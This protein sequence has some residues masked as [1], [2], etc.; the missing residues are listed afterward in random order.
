MRSSRAHWQAKDRKARSPNGAAGMADDEGEE[1]HYW[2]PSPDEETF[3]SSHGV[4]GSKSFY[5]SPRGATLF[6]RAWLPAGAAPP[7]AAVCMVH[8][9]GNDI[10]WTF[11]S[12]AVFLAG[13][14][15]ACFALD[16]PGHGRSAGLRAFVPSVDAVAADCAAFFAHALAPFPPALPRFL[17]GESMGAA[18]CLLLHLRREGQEEEEKQQAGWAGAVLVAPMLRLSDRLR[19]PWPLPQIL[20][21]VARVAPELAVVPTAD[22]VE[23]SVRV[24]EKRAVARR[25]PRRYAGRPRLGTVVE[26]MRVTEY[27]YAR[28]EEVRLPFLVVHGTGDAVTD[29]G[30]SRA[31]YERAASADKTA[32]IL[33]GLLHSL[34]FGETDDNVALVR[35]LILDWLN[36]RTPLP[37]D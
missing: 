6:T 1:Q 36:R 24:A 9:Y 37:T 31:L 7:R 15:Y 10:S 25:N 21:V 20:K 3:Y 8:G 28:L 32:E 11:Q 33:D 35:R 19:P 26:L 14:G 34:L 13:A 5:K 12:T 18:I 2:G 4:R 22:L 29:A 17:Y 23:A 27:L 16:L 30:V